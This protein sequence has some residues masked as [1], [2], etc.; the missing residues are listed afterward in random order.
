MIFL[1]RQARDKHKESSKT[2]RFLSGGGVVD[3]VIEEVQDRADGIIY[4]PQLR[5]ERRLFVSLYTEN[6]RFTSTGSGQASGKYS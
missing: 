2:Y 4:D 1:P 3:T 6:D 5:C